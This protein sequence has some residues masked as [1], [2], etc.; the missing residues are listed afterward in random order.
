MTKTAP[1]KIAAD[2]RGL[3]EQIREIGAMRLAALPSAEG[4]LAKADAFKRAVRCTPGTPE[5]GGFMR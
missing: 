3:D 2:G 5:E 4:L 1:T